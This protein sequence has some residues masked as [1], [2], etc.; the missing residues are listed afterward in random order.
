M[1]EGQRSEDCTGRSTCM[2]GEMK[3]RRQK[4]NKGVRGKGEERMKG[5]Q[6]K[7]DGE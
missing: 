6:T 2:A 3:G 5:R 7:Q 1:E 4:Q